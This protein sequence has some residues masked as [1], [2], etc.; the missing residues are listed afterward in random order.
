M[1][2]LSPN[3][4][5]TIYRDESYE[6]FL[7]SLPQQSA[8]LESQGFFDLFPV[9]EMS[10]YST[11]RTHVYG[12][13]TEQSARNPGEPLAPGTMAQGYN[14]WTAIR[15]EFS[16]VRTIAA[17]YLESV[18][19]LGDYAQLQGTIQ[20]KNY[21]Q[22][23]ATYLT[24]L[25]AYGGVAPSTLTD[26]GNGSPGL[27]PRSRIFAQ[28]LKG[29]NGAIIAEIPKTD[30][31]DPDTKRWFA[32]VGDEHIRANGDTSASYEGKTLG[33]FNAGSSVTGGNMI[34]SESNL[35]GVLLHMENDLP[36]GPDR[37]FYAPPMPDT[38]I[39]SGNLRSTAAQIV[40]LNEYRLNTPNNDKNVMFRQSKVFGIKKIIVNRFLPDNCWYIATSGYGVNLVYK[41]GKPGPVGVDGPV[42]GSVSNI[43]IDMNSQTWVRQ[44]FAYWTHWFDE[45][46]D[47]TWYAGST[48]TALGSAA[49]GFRPT[50]PA[51]ADLVDWED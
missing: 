42:R 9:K 33:F 29:E 16:E 11:F 12:S 4:V 49:T 20:A 6:A 23:F 7:T 41:T 27:R 47:M 34:L 14:Y 1:P 43:Y 31:A 51:T 45:N 17:E 30:A 19:K 24:D 15:A 28:Y 35:Q 32:R 13:Y 8:E 39:V 2:T 48:P 40:D 44:F 37:K 10:A 18:I 3:Q 38:L 25:L 22:S 50:A 5:E 36:W 26:T 46:M 21:A